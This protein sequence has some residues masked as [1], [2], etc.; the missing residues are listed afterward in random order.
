[1][2][3]NNFYQSLLMHKKILQ[4]EKIGISETTFCNVYEFKFNIECFFIYTIEGNLLLSYYSNKDENNFN[5][6]NIFKKIITSSFL[7]GNFFEIVIG[8]NKII[9]FRHF[10]VYIII[11]KNNIK[12][13]LIKFYLKFIS[14][15]YL[16]FI[17]ENKEYSNNLYY[18][19][20]I[21]E[22]FFIKSL[23]NKFI[24]ILKSLIFRAQNNASQI[25][26][27]NITIIDC[28]NNNT[29]LFNLKKII[30]PKGIIRTINKNS[31]IYQLLLHNI[32]KF[33]DYYSTKMVLLS[34]YPRLYIISKYLKINNG[35]GI[36]ELY[37]SN[38][39]SRT[40]AEYF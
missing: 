26:F 28:K 25:K 5:S 36:I 1:M 30:K 40:S 38:R 24:K 9:L 20:N 22:N 27:K 13:S 8:K 18:I 39:L 34:T 6:K 32:I 37:S 17:G 12:G 15:A 19:S 29:I 2:N 10:L 23:T 16:N 7:K 35:I 3:Y 21:F 11:T 33:K 14:N 4:I 31:S